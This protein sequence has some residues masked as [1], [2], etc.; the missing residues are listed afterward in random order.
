MRAPF[1]WSSAIG[2]SGHV[3]GLE[4]VQRSQ[5]RTQQTTPCKDRGPALGTSGDQA[6]GDTSF[7]GVRPH[8]LGLRGLLLKALLVL[9]PEPCHLLAQG[10]HLGFQL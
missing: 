10:S 6:E 9:S 3:D 2:L 4:D 7:L 1:R 5:G 8:Y